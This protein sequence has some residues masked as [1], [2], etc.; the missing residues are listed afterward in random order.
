MFLLFLLLA[1]TFFFLARRGKVGPPPWI[2]SRHSPEA[3]ARRVLAQRFA[4]GDIDSE[5]FIERASVLNWTPGSDTWE[6][7]KKG[8]KR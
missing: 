6:T 5:E 7:P 1:G 3:E 4:Q 2:T 8:K